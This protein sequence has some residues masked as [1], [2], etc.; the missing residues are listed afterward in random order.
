MKLTLLPVGCPAAVQGHQRVWTR[1]RKGVYVLRDGRDV[2][3]NRSF[4]H[5]R[6]AP[7]G[8]RRAFMSNAPCPAAGGALQTDSPRADRETGMRAHRTVTARIDALL[9]PR[10]KTT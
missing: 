2:L 1:Y 4:F 6:R 9:K 5:A 8:L 10:R 7:A 3:V